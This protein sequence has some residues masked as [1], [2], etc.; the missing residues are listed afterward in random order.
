MKQGLRFCE[1]IREKGGR[2]EFV[3]ICG[4]GHGDGCWTPEAMTIVGQFLQNY[5]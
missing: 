3:K 4:A 1:K 2:A 5:N